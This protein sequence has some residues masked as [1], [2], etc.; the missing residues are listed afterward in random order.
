MRAWIFFHAFFMRA[1][2]YFSRVFHACVDFFPCVFHS[3]FTRAWILRGFFFTPL[4][5]PF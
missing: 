4:V 3:R 5:V 2:I 1:W